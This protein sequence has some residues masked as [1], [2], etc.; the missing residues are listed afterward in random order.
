MI[1]DACFLLLS[2]LAAFTEQLTMSAAFVVGAPMTR[3][4]DSSER[5]VKASD[6]C[7]LNFRSV[8]L[9]ACLKSWWRCLTKLASTVGDVL[10]IY[11]KTVHSLLIIMDVDWFMTESVPKSWAERK[12]DRLRRNQKCNSFG[13][14]KGLALYRK[15]GALVRTNSVSFTKNAVLHFLLP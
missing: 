3:L 10:G 1:Y 14:S 9:H 15:Q 2:A 8:H 13:T 6:Q 7:H 11:T 12:H 4:M 5:P